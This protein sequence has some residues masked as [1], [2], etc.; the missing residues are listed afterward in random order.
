[1]KPYG[2]VSTENVLRLLEHQDHRCALTERELTPETSSLDHIVP[3]RC[4]GEH[5]IE[6]TQVLHSEVNRAKGSLTNAEFIELCREVVE[7][8]DSKSEGNEERDA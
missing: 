2:P 4:G 8:I 5:A 3:I 7:H 1:M 6:N